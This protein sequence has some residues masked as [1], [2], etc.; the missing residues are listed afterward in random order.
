MARETQYLNYMRRLA[1]I[2][3]LAPAW[4]TTKLFMG[5]KGKDRLAQ[6]TLT[7]VAR[8]I[9]GRED[10]EVLTAYPNFGI[11]DRNDG[12]GRSVLFHH[13]HFIEA[14]YHAMSTAA[15]LVFSDHR[16]PSDVYAL[17]GVRDGA[18]IVHA[19][20]ERHDVVAGDGDRV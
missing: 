7:T 11:L 13:G 1:R 9:A 18:G 3:D 12:Q 14:I 2:E 16:I 20:A 15:S 8:K 17:E 4:H 19:R 6:A 5:R 10:L